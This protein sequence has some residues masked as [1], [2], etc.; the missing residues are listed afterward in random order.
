MR[1]GSCAPSPHRRRLLAACQHRSHTATECMLS[2]QLDAATRWRTR[3]RASNDWLNVVPENVAAGVVTS[4]LSV[5]E[6]DYQENGNRR[7]AGEAA[8]LP[9][10]LPA[11]LGAY[12]GLGYQ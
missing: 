1:I 7:N 5:E 4:W 8:G 12:W 10:R 2:G 6:N 11:L 9:F 3:Q